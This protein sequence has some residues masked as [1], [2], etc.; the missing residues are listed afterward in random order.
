MPRAT[1]LPR[2]GAQ[3]T[4][5]TGLWLPSTFGRNRRLSHGPGKDNQWVGRVATI[6]RFFVYTREP[7]GEWVLATRG[8]GGAVITGFSRAGGSEGYPGCK[9]AVDLIQ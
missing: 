4:R 8:G 5:A 2:D 6:K 7:R 9:L 1:R 3:T